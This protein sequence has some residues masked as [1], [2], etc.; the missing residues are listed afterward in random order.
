MDTQRVVAALG[1]TIPEQVVKAHTHG[2]TNHPQ[3][4]LILRGRLLLWVS[5]QPNISQGGISISYTSEQR[6][7]MQ[8]EAR[9][10]FKRA[11]ATTDLEGMPEETKFGYRGNS[12]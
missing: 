8:R 4:D 1:V 2:L 10:L 12:L 9:S 11:G 5:L 6:L 7:L 3:G